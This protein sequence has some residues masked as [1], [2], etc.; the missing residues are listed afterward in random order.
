MGWVRGCGGHFDG[1]GNMNEVGVKANRSGFALRCSFGE[2]F[3]SAVGRQDIVLVL[4]RWREAANCWR[5]V[6]NRIAFGWLML[7][8]SG[9]IQ[10]V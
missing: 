4:V 7:S 5:V 2:L 3:G 1:E 8:F 9:L 6:S 10:Y